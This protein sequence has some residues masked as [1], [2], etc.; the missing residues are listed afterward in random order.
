MA[1]P[2]HLLLYVD[3]AA[4]SGRF[5]A[6]LL[7]LT[8]MDVSDT[9]VL[10]T[11]PSGMFLALWSRDAVLPATTTTGGG[12]EILF[13]APDHATLQAMH[14]DWAARGIA[15]IQPP[16]DQD[17]GRSFVA[18]DPDGHRLRVMVRSA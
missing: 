18:T 7:D 17:F 8:P 6:D 9:F 1:T 5:Y 15:I 4:A 2:T 3:N 11:L 14:D 13:R 16:T 10:F 12:T